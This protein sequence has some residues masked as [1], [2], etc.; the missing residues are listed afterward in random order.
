MVRWS[1]FTQAIFKYIVPII[2]IIIICA[3]TSS[4]FLNLKLWSVLHILQVRQMVSQVIQCFCCKILVDCAQRMVPFIF[5]SRANDDFG[6]VCN[7]MQVVCES[8]D[9]DRQTE[10]I[11]V[12]RVQ[13]FL[14]ACIC[15]NVFDVD[16][17][18]NHECWN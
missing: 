5:V 17:L 18:N 4:A 8:S 13:W 9:T 14:L 10:W 15:C 16:D 3:G 7:G 2:T 12:F 11:I 6:Y 1:Y